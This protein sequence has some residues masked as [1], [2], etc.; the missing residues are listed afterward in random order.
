MKCY[1][2]RTALILLW[3]MIPVGFGSIPTVEIDASKLCPYVVAT[4]TTK[5][6]DPNQT[7][8]GQRVEVR[9]CP[10][11]SYKSE[12]GTLQFVAWEAN[13][14]FPSLVIDTELRWLKQLVM[15]Q[16]AY[17][18]ETVSASSSGVIGIVFEN[19]KPR[20]AVRDSTK[21]DISF[22]SD[23]NSIT[24]ELDDGAGPKR[25]YVLRGK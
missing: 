12:I 11:L 7:R 8:S 1:L 13:A 14:T 19:G 25:I 9:Q 2:K 16:D 5:L 20:Q 10:L 22:R 6:G 17:A 23:Q 21:G 15:V 4:L 18:F 24:I 3:G